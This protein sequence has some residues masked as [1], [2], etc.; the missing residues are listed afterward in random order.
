MEAAEEIV[1]LRAVL[2]DLECAFSKTSEIP[3]TPFTLH[4][5]EAIRRVLATTYEQS[6]RSAKAP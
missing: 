3:E 6:Q 4:A 2:I 1:R 5:L